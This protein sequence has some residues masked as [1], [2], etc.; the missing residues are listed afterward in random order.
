[1]AIP[2]PVYVSLAVREYAEGRICITTDRVSGYLTSHGQDGKNL[3]RNVLEWTGQRFSSEIV[4]IGVIQTAPVVDLSYLNLFD[5]VTYTE[6]TLADI[7]TDISMYDMIYFVGLPKTSSVTTPMQDAL[8]VYVREGGGILIEAPLNPEE[9]I[10]VLA[11]IEYI[12]CSS[13]QPPTYDLSFWTESGLSHYVF[14]KDAKVGFYATLE[15]NNFSSEWT[16]L[17]TNIDNHVYNIENNDIYYPTV[18][19]SSS[20]FGA[21]YTMAFKN[22]IVVL[23]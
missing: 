15:N 18:S 19:N 17:M 6:I 10:N 11:S 8:E 5:Y 12:Y 21:G 16:L 14:D 2:I 1:M 9:N 22:G 4:N 7:T 23:E 13:I 3:W 20:E